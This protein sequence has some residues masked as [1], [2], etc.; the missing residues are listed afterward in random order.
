[1]FD[2]SI[3]RKLIES[4]PKDGEVSLGVDTNLDNPLVNMED[5]TRVALKS[6]K[7]HDIGKGLK[8]FDGFDTGI[9]HCTPA[10]FNAIECCSKEINDTS[11]SGGVRTLAAE[12]KVNA[13]DIGNLYWIDVDDP[14]ALRWAENVLLEHLPR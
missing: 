11:L 4:P 1:V 6:G 3:A 14:G 8:S 2:P 10:I 13:V 9:F 5:V 12:G 7:V